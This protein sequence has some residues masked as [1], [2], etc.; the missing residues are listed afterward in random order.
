LVA[1]A[2]FAPLSIVGVQIATGVLLAG[3]LLAL[4]T[5][6]RRL[7]TAELLWPVLAFLVV[8]YLASLV[9]PVAL[10]WRAWTAP[11]PVL[12]LLVV[13]A[14]LRVVPEPE[15]TL[16]RVALTLL[17]VGVAVALLGLYQRGSGFDLNH[18]LGLRAAPFRVP[19][20]QGDGFSAVGTF[21][22][23]LTFSAIE[24]GVLLVALAI[25]LGGGSW[26]VRAF[27]A[28]AALPVAAAITATYSRAAW[29]G[30]GLGAL[31][32]VSGLRRQAAMVLLAL[33]TTAAVA[34]SS[35]P[36]V[37]ERAA[38]A[39]RATAN[40]DRLFIWSRAGEVI[41]DHPVLGV[42]VYGYPVVA[43][44]Y[45]D[46]VDPLFPMRTWAHDMPMTLLAETGIGGLFCWIWML[47]AAAAVGWR[48][49]RRRDG[50]AR[51]I[52]L[53]A[54]AGAAAFVSYGLFHD[55]LYDGESALTMFF[56][57]GLACAAGPREARAPE[58]ASELV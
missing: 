34:G 31:I 2:A 35:V 48:E 22:S 53:G 12:L 26:K 44:P 47:I 39:L 13:P 3:V 30:V 27:A 16:K 9:S 51:A 14:A 49:L 57:A 18:A 50:L 37:R 52:R 38:S 36:A 4:A 40:Q 15:R 54:L 33:A 10:P 41:A 17:G 21:N 20:P 56:L 6:E 32:L 45:Y 7:V 25:G 1:T 19:S 43:G 23:R 5:G 24:A 55:V 11:R 46:R 8:C 28:L 29:I 42:G 58:P